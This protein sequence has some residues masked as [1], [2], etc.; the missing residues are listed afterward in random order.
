MIAEPA[1]DR[2]CLY[3][4]SQVAVAGLSRPDLRRLAARFATVAELVR[5]IRTL[6]QRDDD[7]APEDGPKV[8]C[9]VPQRARVAPG[10][11]NCVERSILFLILAE[12]KSW[13]TVLQRQVGLPQRIIFCS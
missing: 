11:P 4:L 10:N 5:W 1:N 13:F 3:Q 8:A 9:D 12:M 7:G 6:P 2:E